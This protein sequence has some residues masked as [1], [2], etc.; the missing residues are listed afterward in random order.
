[1]TI[2]AIC[3]K[4]VGRIRTIHE[5][6]MENPCIIGVHDHLPIHDHDTFICD[7]VYSDKLWDV[8]YQLHEVKCHSS[9]ASMIRD[10]LVEWNP[11]QDY[12]VTMVDISHWPLYFE[13]GNYWCECVFLFFG[14]G[15]VENIRFTFARASCIC[16]D[17]KL[18]L[19]LTRGKFEGLHWDPRGGFASPM[20]FIWVPRWS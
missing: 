14:C 20:S 9:P 5:K 16:W 17:A 18:L 10:E 7:I 15:A 4:I 19:P 11:L 8:H 13:D 6:N 3:W 2:R 12:R 1:M